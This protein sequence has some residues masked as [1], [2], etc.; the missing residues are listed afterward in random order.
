MLPF[1]VLKIVYKP[2]FILKSDFLY[3]K[4]RNA[5]ISVFRNFLS[6]LRTVFFFVCTL[7]APVYNA[8]VPLVHVLH[9][10]TLM[11]NLKYSQATLLLN[12]LFINWLSQILFLKGTPSECH[13]IQDG[14]NVNALPAG[15]VVYSIVYSLSLL[16]TFPHITSFF[17][18]KAA[19]EVEK[20]KWCSN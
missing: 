1:N 12:M 20:I 4:T 15:S 2:N 6:E 19:F 5:C 8:I 14:N 17:L 11:L 16:H 13:C 3:I 9:L 7:A 18:S 10:Y